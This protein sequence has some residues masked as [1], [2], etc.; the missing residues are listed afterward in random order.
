MSEESDNEKTEDPTPQRKQKARE[1]GQV[2]RSRELTTLAML[3]VG[4]GLMLAGGDYLVGNLLHLLHNGL[5]FDR[6]LVRDPQH[7]LDQAGSLI[8]IAFLALLPLVG[9]LYIT[10]VSAPLII[11][12]LNLSGK[13]IKLNLKKL[14]PI[15]GIKRLF[16]AQML[17]EMVKAI[18]KVLL[19]GVGGGLFLLH[20]KSKF[21]GLMFE[22]LSMALSDISG[23]L[24]GCMLII[25]LSLIPMVAFDVIYQLWSN[26]KKLRMSRQEVKDEFKKQE[27]DPQLKGRIRQLQRQMAQQRMM[28]DV[29]TADVVVNNPTHYSVALKYQE[30]SMGAPI[31]VAK[32][33]GLIALRIRELAEESRIPMLEAPPLARALYRHCEPGAPVPTELYNAVAE[34]LA[35]VYG[36][37]RWRKGYGIRPQQPKD[38]PVPAAL[39]FAQESESDG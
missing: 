36:L 22:P 8:G 31:V 7:M 35:W 10:A 32:G 6:L 19:A 2:P 21:I 38:L 20:N 27:G 28:T 13:A 17:S 9:G 39:D 14:N 18:L 15:S 37:R 16:S 26:W 1:E 5:T 29:P 34:V 25:I 4:S 11:G 3:L 30:G 24:I 23:I 12:G 33:S